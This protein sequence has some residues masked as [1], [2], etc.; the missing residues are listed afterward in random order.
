MSRIDR[1]FTYVDKG[2]NDDKCCW[3]WM[4]ALSRGDYGNFW[5]GRKNKRA[6][7]YSYEHHNKVTLNP[8]QFVC[9]SCD[10]PRCVRPTHLWLG[11]R[12]DNMDDAANKGR[13]KKGQ[14]APKAAFTNQQ[15]LSIR[16]RISNGEK[17][18]H[19]ADEYKVHNVTISRIWLKKVYKDAFKK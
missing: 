5:D 11:T 10:N 17:Q 7:R 3:N 19:I 13:L 2:V 18:Q 14:N 4:G 6:N 9:H 12:Q 8:L 1:F 16:E 15:I